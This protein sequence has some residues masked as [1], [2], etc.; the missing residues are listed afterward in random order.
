[1]NERFS[2][3]KS[4]VADVALASGGAGRFAVRLVRVAFALLGVL[5]CAL[6]MVVGSFIL[7][8][9]EAK[10]LVYLD[11]HGSLF[12]LLF[13]SAANLAITGGFVGVLFATIARRRFT[14]PELAVLFSFCFANNLFWNGLPYLYPFGPY[15][16]LS[17]NDRYASFAGMLLADGLIAACVL[18]WFVQMVIDRSLKRSL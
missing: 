14:D 12:L 16:E 13:S 4:R 7:G 5:G 15:L 10:G 3:P 8:V 6:L 11:L 9:V 18:G 2:P 1:M 17:A